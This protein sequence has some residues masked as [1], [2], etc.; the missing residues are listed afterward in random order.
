[1]FL[2]AQVKRVV[3]GLLSEEDD[4]YLDMLKYL[5]KH[6]KDYGQIE[7]AKCR[8]RRDKY[9]LEADK[10]FDIES[11]INEVIRKKKY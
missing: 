4:K 1:M 8:L 11:E 6:N 3:F 10:Q 7:V 9:Q 2:K 5:Q